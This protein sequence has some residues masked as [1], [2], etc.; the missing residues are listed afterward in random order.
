MGLQVTEL[1]EQSAPKRPAPPPAEPNGHAAPSGQ[2]HNLPN[3]DASSSAA[4][5]AVPA[6]AA[7]ASQNGAAGHADDMETDGPPGAAPPASTGPAL[8]P[9]EE[10]YLDRFERLKGILDGTA[11]ISHY[12]EFLYS[13]NHADLQVWHCTGRMRHLH[14]T[15]KAASTD[16]FSWQP[17]WARRV[18]GIAAMLWVPIRSQAKNPWLPY[19]DLKQ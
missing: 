9:E 11:S 17:T 1:L 15:C 13:H 12:L 7:A 16:P 19:R 6:P 18:R 14:A 8:K 4:A 5:A 3:G 10:R 2:A